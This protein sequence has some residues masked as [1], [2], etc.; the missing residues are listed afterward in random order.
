MKILQYL[1]GFV[2]GMFV[3]TSHA[4]AQGAVKMAQD[5][6]PV[7]IE[8]QLELSPE[9]SDRLATLKE[10]YAVEQGVISD[11][12]KTKRTAIVTALDAAAPDRKKV[13]AIVADINQL[14]AQEMGKRIDQVFAIR[15]ILTPEQNQKLLQ[16]IKEK[17]DA[18][19][20]DSGKATKGAPKGKH[21]GKKKKDI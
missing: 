8:A 1:T 4:H 11:A 15:A 10:K 7:D 21:H 14:S 13:D 3:L 16:L 19:K 6:I 17:R 18:A 5:Q 2:F 12:L 9:Q 20:A